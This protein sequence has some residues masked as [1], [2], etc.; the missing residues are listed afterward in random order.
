MRICCCFIFPA[1]GLTDIADGHLYFATVDTELEQHNPLHSTAVAAEFVNETMSRSRSRHQI[2]LLDCC[3]SGVFKEGMLA[4]GGQDVGAGKQLQ[5]LGRIVLTASDAFQYSFEGEQVQGHG[6]GSVFTSA[7]V[8]GLETGE[9]DLDRDG[10]FSLDEVYDYV[11]GR[12]SA[13]Q[14]EQKPMKMGFVEGKIF[15]GSNPHPQPADLDQDLLESLNDRRPWVR[16]GAVHELKELLDSANRGQV[17]GARQALRSTA[18]HDDSQEVRSAAEECL[19]GS[20]NGKKTPPTPIAEPEHEEAQGPV[21]VS[22]E[23]PPEHDVLPHLLPSFSAAADATARERAAADLIDLFVL[24]GVWI[25]CMTMA[26]LLPPLVALVARDAAGLLAILAVVLGYSISIYKT[27]RTP[28]HKRMGTRIVDRR[29][30]RLTYG[31]SLVYC[32]AWLTWSVGLPMVII[33]PFVYWYL[34]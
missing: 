19:S 14:P 8:H 16:L 33:V 13:E 21:A 15:I 23:G 1:Q 24:L 10:L 9:A 27:G 22:T 32:V 17:L 4:K 6:V 2:L 31:R 34:R 5:G 26:S 20:K 11:Y 28:G 12:V 25:T 30:K 29:G 7:L 3:Y 18:D